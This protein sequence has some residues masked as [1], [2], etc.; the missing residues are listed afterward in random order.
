MLHLVRSEGKGFK[1]AF[2]EYHAEN[3]QDIGSHITR[4][5]SIAINTYQRMSDIEQSIYDVIG[6]KEDDLGIEETQMLM[7][8]IYE[9]ALHSQRLRMGG[10]LAKLVK[11]NLDQLKAFLGSSNKN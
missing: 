1:T 4:I 7:V 9:A 5:Y 8:L 3:E 10:R 2:Y 6:V 11:T